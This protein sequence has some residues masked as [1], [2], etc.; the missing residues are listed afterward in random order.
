[1][2]VR[3]PMAHLGS[4]QDI[5]AR[6]PEP[7]ARPLRLWR[8][9]PPPSDGSA[10]ASATYGTDHAVSIRRRSRWPLLSLAVVPAV[11]GVSGAGSSTNA[12]FHCHDLRWLKFVG[13]GSA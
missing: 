6:Q 13:L 12:R 1:M 2:L 11:V 3:Q 7:L 4:C 10:T 9:P 8:R 5:Q